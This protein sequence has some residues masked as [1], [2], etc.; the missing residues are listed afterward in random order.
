MPLTDAIASAQ[1]EIED[2]PIE[3]SNVLS[4]LNNSY[5]VPLPSIFKF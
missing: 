1:E 3:K 5:V 4:L 2:R